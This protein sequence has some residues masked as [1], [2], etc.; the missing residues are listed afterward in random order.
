MGVFAH[1][2]RMWYG[3]AV[4]HDDRVCMHDD[5]EIMVAFCLIQGIVV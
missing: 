5:M 3:I 1:L 2:S 4:S